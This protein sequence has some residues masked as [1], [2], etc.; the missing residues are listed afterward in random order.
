MSMLTRH[1]ARGLLAFSMITATLLLDGCAL[2]ALPCRV[3]SATL[4]IVP[5]VGHAAA[6]PFDL[7]AN[8]ID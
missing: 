7:C 3:T 1:A 8:A 5:V 2:A 6:S 4:K